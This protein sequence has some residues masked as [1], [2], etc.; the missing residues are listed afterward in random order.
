MSSVGIF[1][2]GV[3]VSLLVAFA[4]GGLIW[5]AIQDGRTQQEYDALK[6]ANDAAAVPPR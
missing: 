2:A 6:E 5:G 1:F 4:L 3:I